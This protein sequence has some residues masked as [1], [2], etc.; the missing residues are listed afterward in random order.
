MMRRCDDDELCACAMER[1]GHDRVRCNVHRRLGVVA[2]WN[3][4]G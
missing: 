4:D 3:V 2:R 1:E